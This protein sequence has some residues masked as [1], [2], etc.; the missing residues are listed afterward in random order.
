ML[1]SHKQIWNLFH[2]LEKNKLGS[3]DENL[4]NKQNVFD[5]ELAGSILKFSHKQWEAH[6]CDS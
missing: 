2:Q 6:V 1:Y 3:A 5:A 4:S